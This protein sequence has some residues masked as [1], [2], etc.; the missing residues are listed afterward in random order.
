MKKILIIAFLFAAFN[1]QAQTKAQTDS[2]KLQVQVQNLSTAVAQ[3]NRALVIMINLYGQK[4]QQYS[5]LAAS[6]KD[7]VKKY[8]GVLIIADKTGSV[9]SIGDTVIIKR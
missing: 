2:L 1:T 3:L 7:S 9:I 4:D 6:I 8:Q 5:T